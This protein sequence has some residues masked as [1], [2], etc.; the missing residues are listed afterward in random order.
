[1]SKTSQYSI[2][3]NLGLWTKNKSNIWATSAH[4]GNIYGIDF[5]LGNKLSTLPLHYNE[6][7]QFHS[8]INESKHWKARGI[9]RQPSNTSSSMNYWLALLLQ[10]SLYSKIFRKISYF[11][12]KP[13][14]S[15]NYFLYMSKITKKSHHKFCLYSSK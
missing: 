11:S 12:N 3:L 5:W 9:E 1:M 4:K 13:I 15:Y 2:K 7:Q 10:K 14:I 6:T 8:L